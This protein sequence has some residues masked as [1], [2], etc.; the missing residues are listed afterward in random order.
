MASCEQ[1]YYTALKRHR[2]KWQ[3][4]WDDQTRLSQ[5][6]AGQHQLPLSEFEDGL[7]RQWCP[8]RTAG[9]DVGEQLSWA[10]LAPPLP[11]TGAG[12][13]SGSDPAF[14]LSHR[15]R[16]RRRCQMALTVGLIFSD[17]R[18]SGAAYSLGRN[19]AG[20]AGMDGPFFAGDGS[21]AEAQTAS[22]TSSLPTIHCR[23]GSTVP[24]RFC[25]QLEEMTLGSICVLK[26][27]S[28][29]PGVAPG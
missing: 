18:R 20:P 17:Q 15:L 8:P 7:G 10:P 16:R 13:R 29:P 19:G 11:V 9:S 14:G 1:V 22:E 25:Y 3:E 2:R 23:L 28:S 4:A 26:S 12:G 21:E 5:T 24:S 6:M 27:S